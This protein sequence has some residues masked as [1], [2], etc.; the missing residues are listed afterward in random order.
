[1]AATPVRP[2]SLSRLRADDA[3]ADGVSGGRGGVEG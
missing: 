1:V 2:S 3:D